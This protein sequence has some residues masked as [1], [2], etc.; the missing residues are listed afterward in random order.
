MVAD[1]LVQG[2][3]RMAACLPQHAAIWSLCRLLDSRAAAVEAPALG[4]ET[5]DES[6]ATAFRKAAIRYA[7]QAWDS[8]PLLMV[9]GAECML[10]RTYRLAAGVFAEALRLAPREPLV[11]LGLACAHLGQVMSRVTASQHNEAARTAALLLNYRRLR[12][13]G[14]AWEREGEEGALT[15]QQVNA[16]VCYNSGRA[17]HQ[18]GLLELAAE[19]YERALEGWVEDGGSGSDEATL[20]VR[21][22]AAFNLCLIYR[23]S[24][25]EARAEQLTRD[26]LVYA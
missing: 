3:R 22:E 4:G 19:N 21:R 24:G 9:L 17:C 8:L 7:A 11:S 1:S 2:A 18:L 15:F 5:E 23:A 6:N 25:A 14:A 26:F 13:A 12:F 20:N 16:E 10:A